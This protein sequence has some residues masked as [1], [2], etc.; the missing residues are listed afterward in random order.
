[1]VALSVGC[2]M[3]TPR[4]GE[5]RREGRRGGGEA[6]G[7]GG[8]EEGR[9]GG[10]GEGRGREGRGRE[11]E[12]GEEEEGTRLDAHSDPKNKESITKTVFYILIKVK[13]KLCPRNTA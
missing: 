3:A 10:Q 11:E 8:G 1:M 2:R 4:G 13:F 6:R 12:E 9:R 5:G 7:R